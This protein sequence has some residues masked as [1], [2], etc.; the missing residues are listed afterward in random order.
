MM[1]YLRTTE[2]RGAG[3]LIFLA[4]VIILSFSPA[5]ASFTGGLDGFSPGFSP[6]PPGGYIGGVSPFSPNDPT[7]G[8]LCPF[9]GDSSVGSVPGLQ[10][11]VQQSTNP[12]GSSGEPQ[13]AVSADPGGSTPIVQ[14]PYHPEFIPGNPTNP[15]NP[16]P[17]PTKV[18]PQ[19]VLYP[20]PRDSG[21]P[22]FTAQGW[23]NITYTMPSDPDD[24]GLFEDLTADGTKDFG[25]VI[26]F[27]TNM[28][29]ISA[30]EPVQYFDFNGDQNISFGDVIAL[31]RELP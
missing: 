23:S 28:E 8:D 29:W 1:N 19:P 11:G 2:Y 26:L 21:V 24:D 4:I 17:V 13:G 14:C 3:F 27:F 22:R 31:F 30:N 20:V 10:S 9:T 18:V 6:F 16:T 12:Q 5:Q 7:L 15:T 25:D